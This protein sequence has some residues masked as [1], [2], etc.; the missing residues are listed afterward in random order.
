MPYLLEEIRRLLA[1]TKTP[2]CGGDMNFMINLALYNR[3]KV[4]HNEKVIHMKKGDPFPF[5]SKEIGLILKTYLDD[6]K[7]RYIRFNDCMG[8]LMN[9]I[10]EYIRRNPNNLPG[11]ILE[12][13][14]EVGFDFAASWYFHNCAEYEDKAIVKNGDVFPKQEE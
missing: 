7:I 13:V 5:P 3:Y 8:A 10:F 4:L 1:K 6:D 11:A 9:G 2:K 14:A 12:R